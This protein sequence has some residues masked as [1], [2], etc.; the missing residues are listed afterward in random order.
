MS[1]HIHT[2]KAPEFPL[3]MSQALRA[4]DFVYV[5]GQVGVYPSTREIVGPTIEEQTEQCLRNIEIILEEAGLTLDHVIKINAYISRSEDF[6]A[7]NRT[8]EQVFNKPFPTRTSLPSN[9]SPYL[10][11]IDAIAYAP[12]R[13]GQS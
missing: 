10:I 3:P 13:R 7:Y 8:Y 11:E 9:L 6:P 1:E 5:S 4:G 2:N 12:S